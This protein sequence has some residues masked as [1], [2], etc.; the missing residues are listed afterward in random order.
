MARRNLTGR[1]AALVVSSALIFLAAPTLAQAANALE[2]QLNSWGNSVVVTQQVTSFAG[3]RCHPAGVSRM[4]FH[5]VGSVWPYPGPGNGPIPILGNFT[6]SG[7]LGVGPQDISAVNEAP[8]SGYVLWFIERFHVTLNTGE[9]FHGLE[10]LEPVAPDTPG[11][12]GYAG[13]LGH[14]NVTPLEPT[15]YSF[16][17]VTRFLAGKQ[18]GVAFSETYPIYNGAGVIIETGFRNHFLTEGPL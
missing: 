12:T 17:T 8:D 10:W 6:A 13:N 18:S 3:S 7:S 1:L 15:S 4:H 9:H 5:A 16:S 11:F 2:L 14:C